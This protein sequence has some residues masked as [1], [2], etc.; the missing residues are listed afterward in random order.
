LAAASTGVSV[1]ESNASKIPIEWAIYGL[2]TRAGRG[3]I[4][5]VWFIQAR[6]LPCSTRGDPFGEP[7]F[8]PTGTN[9]VT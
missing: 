6:P 5:L 3:Y 1:L 9:I 8:N 4:G 2:E 7:T